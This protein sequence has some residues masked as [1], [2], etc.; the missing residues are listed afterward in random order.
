MNNSNFQDNFNNDFNTSIPNDAEQA[1]DREPEPEP[2]PLDPPEILAHDSKVFAI[3]GIIFSLF[4]NFVPGIIF[5]VIAC[6]KAKQATQALGEELLDARTGRQL[7]TFGLIYSIVSGI[8]QVLAVFLVVA[9]YIIYF[10]AKSFFC[11]E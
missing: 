10:L 4:V 1:F 11:H 9:I 5:S 6:N 7:S 3:M 8:S 2:K